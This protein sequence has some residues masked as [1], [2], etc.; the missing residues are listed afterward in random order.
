MDCDLCIVGAGAAGIALARELEGSG[1]RICLLESGGFSLEEETQNLYAG[2]STGTLSGP[3]SL[4]L[5]GSRLRFFGGTTNHWQGWTRSLD[6]SDFEERPWVADSGWPISK[7]DLDPYYDRALRLLGLPAHA[8]TEAGLEGEGLHRVIPDTEWLRTA[9]YFLKPVRFGVAFRPGLERSEE[10]RVLLYANALALRTGEDGKRVERVDGATLGGGRFSVHAR[11]F[12]LAAGG[13]ENARLLLLSHDVQAQGLG[14]DHDLVGRYFIDHPHLDGGKALL[15]RSRE[16]LGLYQ[17]HRPGGADF[18]R[19]GALALTEQAQ[20]EHEVLNLSVELREVSKVSE[21]AQH[22]SAAA[23][24][25]DRLGEPSA[26]PDAGDEAPPVMAMLVRSE[27]SPRR[28][29]RV[30][31]DDELDTL[32]QRRAHLHW[33]LTTD[34]RQSIRRGIAVMARELGHHAAGRVR[35]QYYEPEPWRGSHAGYHHLGTTRMHQDPKRGVVDADCRLHG[36]ENLWVAGSS[37]FPT[38]GFANPTFTILALA[39]RLADHLKGQLR[40]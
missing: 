19:I 7:A 32:G 24:A 27:Q 30:T 22:L 3:E 28:D 10:V 31:L 4:Y 36:V 13:V 12:V 2:D 23:R 34:D 25:V 18:A 39:L 17:Y 9:V 8:E 38:S 40:P 29:N 5:L 15:F 33:E 1:A 37:V 20:R 11:R 6:A 26:A 14:N 35:V 16:D 21:T